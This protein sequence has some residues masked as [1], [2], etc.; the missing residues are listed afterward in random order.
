M[1][2]K[3]PK[4]KKAKPKKAT[5][6]TSTVKSYLSADTHKK[7]MKKAEENNMSGSQWI[8]HQIMKWIK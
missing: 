2:P 3:K 7:F 1:K 8:R 5:K 4:P 6:P